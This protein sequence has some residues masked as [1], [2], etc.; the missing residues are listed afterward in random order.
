MDVQEFI[1]RLA[2]LRMP[3]FLLQLAVGVLWLGL[4]A[5]SV[6]RW[7]TRGWWSLT[8]GPVAV[9]GWYWAFFVALFLA[10]AFAESCI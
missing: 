3:Y 1:T 10:C 8:T 7:G 6:R 4:V 2:P 9:L 5:L